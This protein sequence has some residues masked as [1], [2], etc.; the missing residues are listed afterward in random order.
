[1]IGSISS[2]GRPRLATASRGECGIA[3]FNE[4]VFL[5]RQ[6]YR[7]FNDT[8]NGAVA[9]GFCSSTWSDVRELLQMLQKTIFSLTRAAI[10]QNIDL[11]LGRRKI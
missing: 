2:S 8:N 7:V 3:P 6:D 5:R 10:R 11:S 9:F 4:R 1:M